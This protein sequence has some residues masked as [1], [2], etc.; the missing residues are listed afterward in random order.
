MSRKKKK[1]GKGGNKPAMPPIAAAAP[2][3]PSTPELHPPRAARGRWLAAGALV[4]AVLAT[5][6]YFALAPRAPAPVLSAGK[7]AASQPPADYVGAATCKECH[8]NEYNAWSASHHR[9]AMQETN[10]WTV[11]GNFN[12]S[13]LKHFNIESTMFR[14]DGKF[15]VRTD[16]ADGKLADFEINYVFGVWPLQQYLVGFPGGALSDAAGRMGRAHERGGRAALVSPLSERPD[17]PHRSTALGRTL[18]KLEPA[19]RRVPLDEPEKGVRRREQHVQD[20]IQRDL[21]VACEA[22][23]GPASRHN[24]WAKTAKPPYSKDGDKGLIVL[25][26]DWK[27]AWKFSKTDDKFANRDK[28][29]D[30]GAM[31]T[32]AACHARRSTLRKT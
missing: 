2:P 6:I 28:P 23:H 9:V 18:S 11:L 16:G 20:D 5:A 29:T 15:M 31:N 10:E 21:M 24:E 1:P 4:V 17:G 7:S 32:C 8:A 12:N 25:K 26:T 30:P 22:C 27:D 13:K 14:R 19:M 3:M